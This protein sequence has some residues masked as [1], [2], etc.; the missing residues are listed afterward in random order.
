MKRY[1]QIPDFLHIGET[2]IQW[3]KNNARDL[4]WRASKLPY[5]VWISEIILQQTQV[6]QGLPY[7]QKFIARFPT[8]FSLAEA[9]QDEVL[10]YWKGLGYYSRAIN[11]QE[12]AQQVVNDYKGVFPTTSLELEKLKGVGKYTSAAVA[13]ICFEEHIPSVDGNFYRVL[14]RFFGDDF[15]ISSSK[16]FNYFTELAYRLMPEH[17]SGE[18]NQAMM[19]L[20]ANICTPKLAKCEL[21]PISKKCV[22]FNV[23]NV[24]D[25]P[26]KLKKT[27]VESENLHYYLVQHNNQFLIRKRG[28]DS[29]WKNLYEI[30]VKEDVF[31]T[32]NIEEAAVIKHKLS[33]RDLTIHFY[34]IILEDEKTFNTIANDLDY[35]II[36]LSEIGNYSFPKPIDV[37]LHK[38]AKLYL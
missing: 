18:F 38:Q 9:D 31:N 16:S 26:V 3:Y 7:Y 24:Y 6:A 21:C 34:N 15:D 20:G 25:F 17:S 10:L 8:V 23:G 22:A 1:K 2:L 29:I 13:S 5:Q 30:S 35:K 36:H 14:S 12:A 32:L 4:P 19:D 27:K 33:H 28:V 37:F 11:L